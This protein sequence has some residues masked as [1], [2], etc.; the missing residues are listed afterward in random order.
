[1]KCCP[2]PRKTGIDGVNIHPFIPSLQFLDDAD[3][4]M[5]IATQ[6]VIRSLEAR[7]PGHFDRGFDFCGSRK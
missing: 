4:P 7:A 6:R 3:E 2:G 1:M 5:R